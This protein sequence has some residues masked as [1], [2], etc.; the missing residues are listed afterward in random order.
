MRIT[1]EVT[2]QI[3][4]VESICVYTKR[5]F[6]HVVMPLNSAIYPLVFL[7]LLPLCIAGADQCLKWLDPALQP[8]Q[9][10]TKVNIFAM[11]DGKEIVAN[12]F[13]GIS[14]VLD[15]VQKEAS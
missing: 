4:S 11:N 13:S 10:V 9:D 3:T 15:C 1:S 2:V 6:N 14:L 7:A 12:V 8:Y 5:I